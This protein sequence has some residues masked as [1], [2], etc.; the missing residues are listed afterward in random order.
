MMMMSLSAE[1]TDTLKKKLQLLLEE[2]SK[3]LGDMIGLKIALQPLDFVDNAE[4]ADVPDF[5]EGEAP[6]L[7]HTKFREGGGLSLPFSMLLKSQ[8]AKVLAN[9]MLGGSGVSNE[10][11]L[12]E[13]EQSAVGEAVNQ[14]MNGAFYKSSANFSKKVDVATSTV[15]PFEGEE[16]LSTVNPILLRQSV[17]SVHGNYTLS[18]GTTTDVLDFVILLPL[19]WAE[20]FVAL[21]AVADEA[22]PSSALAPPLFDISGI[23]APGTTL[24][25]FKT[26]TPQ[27]AAVTAR[28]ESQP[29]ASAP[30]VSFG[31]GGGNNAAS[32]QQGS[33]SIPPPPNFS[34][35]NPVHSS[36]S[37]TVQPVQFGSLDS[38]VTVSPAYDSSN[39]DLMLDIKINLHVELGRTTMN[40][41][42]ILELGRGTVLELD[43]LAGEPVDLF[44]NGKLIARG[45][46]V[47]IEDNFGLRVTNIVSPQE[48][49]KA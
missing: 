5:F 36:E 14:M 42:E 32:P 35:H 30:S 10:N 11:P 39:L 45:E 16:Q 37:V 21:F 22:P 46:V 3:S 6:L 41:K 44:A 43:R 48:R 12:S 31:G 7:A 29:A 17:Y 8:Q 34:P 26:A 24:E 4:L 9:Y 27:P 1:D 47:V 28:A 23:M 19:E 20:S 2:A 15:T 38:S 18:D 25:S 33:V 49:L 40:I 13:M